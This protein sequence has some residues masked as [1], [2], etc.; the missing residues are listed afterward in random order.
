MTCAIVLVL[1]AYPATGLQQRGGEDTVAA[2]AVVEYD[3]STVPNFFAWRHFFDQ[4]DSAYRLGQGY[5]RHFIDKKIGLK[6]ILGNEPKLLQKIEQAIVER[7]TVAI[8]EN[9]R[10]LNEI[11]TSRRMVKE[12]VMGPVEQQEVELTQIRRQVIMLRRSKLAL[13]DDLAVLAPGSNALVWERIEAFVE[14]Q[15]ESIG[16]SRALTPHDSA[17]WAILV[18]FDKEEE[19]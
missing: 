17:I 9:E 8:R 5:Y 1:A 16:V 15:K 13:H 2:P 19:K 11:A 7:A 14:K 4:A 6:E 3:G 18:S 12:N 10:S